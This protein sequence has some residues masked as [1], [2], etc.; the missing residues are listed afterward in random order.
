MD[1]SSRRWQREENP[2]SP[3]EKSPREQRKPVV[4]TRP[5]NTSGNVP[6]KLPSPVIVVNREEQSG[7][8]KEDPGVDAFTGGSIEDGDHWRSKAVLSIL[9]KSRKEAMVKRGA[10]GLRICE[11]VFCLVSTSVMA[12]DKTQGWSGDSFDR[13]KEYRYCISVTTIAFVYSGFQAYNLAYH[14]ITGKHVIRH[15]LRPYFD[16]SMDQASN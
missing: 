3:P 10:L 16:F 12:V 13:Y 15:H 2:I 6:A 5:E 14:L 9:R 7:V 1:S 11:I 4:D 8:T